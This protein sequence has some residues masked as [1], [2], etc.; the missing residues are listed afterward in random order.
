LVELL[1]EDINEVKWIIVH[2]LVQLMPL[3]A[4]AEPVGGS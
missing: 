1:V 4:Y 3:F 2:N